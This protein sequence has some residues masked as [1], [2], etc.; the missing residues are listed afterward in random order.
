MATQSK[1][2]VDQWLRNSTVR[3]AITVSLLAVCMGQALVSN[4]VPGERADAAQSAGGSSEIER[5]EAQIA[6]LRGKKNSADLSEGMFLL[7]KEYFNAGDLD[8]AIPL[9][10]EALELDVAAGRPT[11]LIHHRLAL[12]LLLQAQRT[13]NADAP[14][15]DAALAEFAAARAAYEKESF[16]NVPVILNS[17][18]MLEYT[19]KHYDKAIEYVKQAAEIATDQNQPNEVAAA[20][21]NL[22]TIATGKGDLEGALAFQQKAVNLLEKAGVDDE[23]HADALCRFAEVL[24]LLNRFDESAAAYNKA[25][26]LEA[27]A[28]VPTLSPEL[29]GS[30]EF[31]LAE[32]M[33]NLHRLPEARQHYQKSVQLLQTNRMNPMFIKASIGLGSTQADLREMDLAEKTHADALEAAVAAKRPDLE[34]TAVMQLSFDSLLR[35]RPEQALQQLLDR[36]KVAEGPSVDPI[37]RGGYTMMIGKCYRTLGQTDAA[38]KYYG[39]ALRAYESAKNP[40]RQAE[41]LSNIA[42][43]YL[44]SGRTAEF[45]MYSG[46]ANELFTLMHDQ[47]GAGTQ[48]YNRGQFELMRGNYTKALPLYESAIAK[49]KDLD[50][51]RSAGALRGK[52]FALLYTNQPQEAVTTFE[53]ALVMAKQAD[54]LEAQWDC[55]LGLGRAYKMLGDAGKAIPFLRSA[56]DL[57]E[58]ER[59]Q[60]TRDSFKTH[61][62]DFRRAC[63]SE[64]TDAYIGQ[65]KPYEALEIA[66]KGKARAFLDLLA[67]RR[68]RQMDLSFV[69]PA[70]TKPGAGE[71]PA[72]QSSST[73]APQPLAA[74]PQ[75]QSDLIASA[76]LGGVGTVRSVEIVPKAHALV[77][78]TMLSPV[79]ANPPNI[80]EIKK[81]VAARQSTCVEYCLFPTKILIWVIKPDL[82]VTTAVVNLKRGQLAKEV[83]ATYA[84]LLTQPKDE[85]QLKAFAQERQKNLKLLY[86]QVVAPIEKDLPKNAE[87]PVTI[88]PDGE[89]FMVP[90]AALMAPDGSY[91][92]EK[93]TL[94]YMPAIGVMRSTQQLAGE[95]QDH[96]KLLAFG[97]PFSPLASSMG[98]PGLPYAEKEVRNIAQLFGPANSEL[99]VGKDAT[100]AAFAS[101][102]P[103]NSCLHLATHG[104][105]DEEQPVKSALVLAPLNGD[106][107]LLTVG[108]I[109]SLKN[110][111]ANL[112]VL[113]AC[114]T[115][116]GK[117]T[118]D[119][120]V[121]LSRAFIIAGTP[122][123]I[124]SQWN[125]DDVMTEYL[126]RHFYQE[127]LAGKP[128][129]QALRDAQLAAIKTLERDNEGPVNASTLRTNPRF[130]AAFQ[131]I[132][133]QR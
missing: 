91:M 47:V 82:T 97:N 96:G 76:E 45:E 84:S 67:N 55:N 98:L 81:L 54:D 111:K 40:L 32:C 69:V 64:L 25:L 129:A 27:K 57:V 4:V 70:D 124:V 121:G 5:L 106:D 61:N 44:D 95:H 68:S 34:V 16:S 122:S 92:M 1:Q 51:L 9:L 36:K 101:L 38:L 118:G 49:L 94:S 85:T 125:V 110:I 102:A 128:K 74:R 24:K 112:I 11:G 35:G 22:T 87:T 88:I 19:R 71:L 41:A 73:Q 13:R 60:L 107:G 7:A 23:I 127:Y 109:L 14:E 131:I 26:Q 77:E 120:V 65:S 12:A 100:K 133:E 48:D 10:K 115:G 56:V 108:D 132:G 86:S 72:S 113:S 37:E 80:E 20:Y 15:F 28:G 79:A 103:A 50:P 52:G 63:Y 21:G 42:V 93:H 30:A 39:D 59:Q 99:K 43:A 116:R 29:L 90:F 117:I 58:K 119:G 17:M 123:V 89:L 130:W 126:M 46:R 104:L 2:S 78:P 105:V 31:G 6:K 8:K 83:Q 66:E 33:W 53:Q 62:L 75:P 18:G 114:R 3:G